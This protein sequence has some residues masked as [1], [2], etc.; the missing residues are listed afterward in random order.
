MDAWRSARLREEVNGK[1]EGLRGWGPLNSNLLDLD[2]DRE[3]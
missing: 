2:R 3:E 1:T